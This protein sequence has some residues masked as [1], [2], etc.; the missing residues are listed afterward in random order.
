MDNK[1]LDVSNDDFFLPD[2][3]SCPMIQDEYLK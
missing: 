1:E 3:S 2:F